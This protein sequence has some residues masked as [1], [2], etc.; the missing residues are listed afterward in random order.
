MPAG[1]I[2]IGPPEELRRAKD[3]PD[4][5]AA[6]IAY[7]E[8]GG[9]RAAA[10]PSVTGPTAE[11]AGTEV[12]AAGLSP[13]RTWACAWRESAEL[14]RDPAR[15]AVSLLGSLLLM[16]AFGF[17]IT[18]DVDKLRFAVLDRDQT[19]ESRLYVD[20]YAGSSYFEREPD[21]ASGSELTRR[22]RANE[23]AL[24]IEIPPRFGGD[25]R[26]GRPTEV[27]VT[28]DGAMP[29]RA[30]TIRGYVQAAHARFLADLATASGAD[31]VSPA[32]LEVRFRYNQ[33][34]RSLDA[35]VPATIALL[36][37]FIPAILGA[38]AVVR[39]KELGSITNLYVTPVTRLEFLLGKQLPYIVLASVN[40]ALLVALAVT[41]FGVA[42]KGSLVGLALGIV[43]YVAATTAIGL[44][45]SCLTSSQTAA[46][47]GTTIATILPATQFSGM[48]QP[49]ST[50]QGGARVIGTLFPATHFM[51]VSVG[52]FTK[53]LGLTD[54]APFLLALLPFWPVLL[55]LS[56]LLLRKQER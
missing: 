8:S 28:I 5:E 35:M 43:L 11:A 23:I 37:V 36:L 17:G 30:E 27:A 32:D 54:L 7:M 55:G 3:A 44:V 31:P 2:A 22:L 24:A 25:L 14:R 40:G 45:A 34:F 38:L 1:L 4:L 20:A 50:L 49:V 18:F 10:L 12:A 42:L 19:P 51:R 15:L 53:G 16:L 47:F 33:A 52:A 29:F 21:L 46:I 6:F 9:R 39:E 26:R 48:L 41:V 56:W 13:R